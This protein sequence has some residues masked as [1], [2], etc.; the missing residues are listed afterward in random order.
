MQNKKFDVAKKSLD[1]VTL[2]FNKNIS[3]AREKSMYYALIP[4]CYIEYFSKTGQV[5]TGLAYLQEHEKTINSYSSPLSYLNQ[6]RAYILIAN[7]FF[8]AKEFKKGAAYLLKIKDLSTSWKPSNDFGFTFLF[9]D[10]L[11]HFEMGHNDILPF[12]TR[13]VSRVVQ[14][15]EKMLKA[16][17][18]FLDFMKKIPPS[19]NKEELGNAFT[20]FKKQLL[21]LVKD[22]EE[23][24]F[25]EVFDYISWIESK[26]KNVSF[27]SVIKEKYEATTKKAS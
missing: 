20:K 9:L 8:I 3:S 24:I 26:I 15:K 18:I 11:F 1:E 16:E 4:N 14:K 2:F 6:I 23:K 22:K 7:L 12:M 25:F 13:S 5:A 27:A 21:P 10:L 19:T 17:K